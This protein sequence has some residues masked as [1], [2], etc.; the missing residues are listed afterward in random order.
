MKTTINAH[1]P[2]EKT[3]PWPMSMKEKCYG[4]VEEDHRNWIVK[5]SENI[6]GM[7]AIGSAAH[8]EKHIWWYLQNTICCIHER[9]FYLS[10]S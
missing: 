4:N 3:T 8:E 10:I 2:V 6:N 1:I 5:K 9:W 7:D